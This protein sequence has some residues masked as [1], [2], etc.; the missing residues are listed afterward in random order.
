MELKLKPKLK[1]NPSSRLSGLGK[2]SF[3]GPDSY[4]KQFLKQLST[5]QNGTVLTLQNPSILVFKKTSS[6]P[7]SHTQIQDQLMQ[8]F[9]DEQ[10]IVDLEMSY[11]RLGVRTKKQGFH[12]E[13]G[14]IPPHFYTHDNRF[15][16][17]VQALDTKSLRIEILSKKNR[18]STCNTT[19][20]SREMLMYRSVAISEL[21][22]FLSY[23]LIFVHWLM[24][25]PEFHRNLRSNS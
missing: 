12:I 10:E 16:F 21:Y 6:I 19:Q 5:I 1:I 2:P 14:D 15:P 4:W 17:L 9:G 7:I 18:Q 11:M 25:R 22:I 20:V 13:S 24:E 8:R 23:N 3:L